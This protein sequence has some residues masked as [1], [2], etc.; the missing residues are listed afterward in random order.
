MAGPVGSTIPLDFDIPR[1]LQ[2]SDHSNPSNEILWLVRAEADVPGVNFD[3]T[4]EVP[5]FQTADS[6]TVESWETKE[7]VAERAH[8]PAA[9]IRPTVVVSPAPEGGTQFYYPAGRSVSAAFGVTLFALLFGGAE[10]VIL[11]LHAPIF[12]AVIFGFFDLLLI[13]IGLNLW[14]GSARIVANASELTLHTNTLGWRGNKRWDASD[15][16][17]LYPKITM[18]SG[19][20]RGVAYYT[21]MLTDRRRN[22]FQ[23]GKAIPDHNEAQWICDQIEQI[24]GLKAKSA[25]A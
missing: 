21:V 17:S 10:A 5:V 24:V 12:F 25:G 19:G 11:R 22:S 13:I 23:L 3:E 15:V 1:N 4:Y 8:P 16:L 20:S 18:Q 2:S 6:P 7:E 14:F 9:P